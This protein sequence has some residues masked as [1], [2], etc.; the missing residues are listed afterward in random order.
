MVCD[1]NLLALNPK[2]DKDLAPL[3]IISKDGQEKSIIDD[4]YAGIQIKNKFIIGALLNSDEVYSIIRRNI[5]G[6]T[7]T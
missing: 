4:Y 6:C 1:F 7:K 2:S 5:K 3:F